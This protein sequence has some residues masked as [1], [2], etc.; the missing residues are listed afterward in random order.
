MALGVQL[1]APIEIVDIAH[2]VDCEYASNTGSDADLVV[3][4]LAGTDDASLE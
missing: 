3:L 2:I 4:G 1:P